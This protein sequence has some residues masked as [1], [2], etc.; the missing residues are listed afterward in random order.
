MS[1]KKK[2]ILVEDNLADVELVKIYIRDF[3]EPVDLVHVGDGYELLQFLKTAALGEI[4]VILLDLNMPRVSG[5]DVLNYMLADPALKKVPIVMFTTSNS[6]SDIAKC[7]DLGAKA[8]VCK[9][10]DIFDFNHAIHS[11]VEFWGR[12]NM[13]PAFL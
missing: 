3:E 5:L 1:I 7:Y 13:L 10:L 11:I 9:P 4:G 12:I 8:F 6:K 2:I